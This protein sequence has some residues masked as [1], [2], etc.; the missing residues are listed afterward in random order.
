MKEPRKLLTVH[1][2]DDVCWQD[3]VYRRKTEKGYDLIVHLVRQPPTREWEIDLADD[4]DEVKGARVVATLLPGKVESVTALRPYYYE[5]DQQPVRTT[6]SPTG[7][8]AQIQVELPPFRYHTLVVIR[9]ATP[10]K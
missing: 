2:P 6:L 4:P 1:A 7:D 5:E 10:T 3:S 9:V 8:P